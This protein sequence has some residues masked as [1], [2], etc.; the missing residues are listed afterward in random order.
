MWPRD[1]FTAI[2]LAIVKDRTSSSK[3]LSYLISDKEEG[4]RRIRCLVAVHP[5]VTVEILEEL[6]RDT[7]SAVRAAVAQSHNAPPSIVERLSEDLDSEVLGC[8]AGRKDVSEEMLIRLSK[9]S[10]IVVRGNI[11][12]SEKTPAVLLIKLSKDKSPWVRKIAE[13]HLKNNKQLTLE[14][15][16]NLM[17]TSDKEEQ[18]DL[19]THFLKAY[20]YLLE[21][22]EEEKEE[23]NA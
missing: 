20:G 22:A 10:D 12:G 23:E 3:E 13:D 11:A 5:N 14:D 6:S 19:L 21:L 16:F 1:N 7:Y 4:T 8:I 15:K 9:N 18:V 17:K 2:K